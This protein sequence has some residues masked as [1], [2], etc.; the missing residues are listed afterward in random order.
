MRTLR[1]AALFLMLVAFLG[2]SGARAAVDPQAWRIVQSIG[3]VSIT[4]PDTAISRPKAGTMLPALSVIVTGSNGRAILSRQGQQ[5]VVQPNS[6]LELTPDAGGRTVLRQLGG[7]ASFNVD[8]RKVPHFEVNTPY[9][10]AAVKGTRFEV[11]VLQNRAEVNVFEGKVEVRSTV[12]RATTLV[13]PGALA[14]VSDDMPDTIRLQERSG[15]TRDITIDEGS[16][17]SGEL[18]TPD[19][20]TTAPD[21]NV[22]VEFRG[23]GSNGANQASATRVRDADSGLSESGRPRGSAAPHLRLGAGAGGTPNRQETTLRFPEGPVGNTLAPNAKPLLGLPDQSHDA[24]GA[25]Q[26]AAQAARQGSDLFRNASRNSLEFPGFSTRNSFV[27]THR[28]NVQGGFPWWE[29]GIGA[30]AILSLL[31]VTA[32]R[33]RI[34][35]RKAR[36]RERDYGD[37]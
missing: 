25:L 26:A 18:R 28:L 20:R 13:T 10:A 24:K 16:L 30:F 3:D 5:I 35:R 33:G 23:G 9:L 32:I 4:G 14:M 37:Y 36:E 11:R 17:D 15:K 6:R 22:A 34:R 1:L 21:L 29:V 12:S 19:L 31:T 7:V 2:A 27:N 8:R